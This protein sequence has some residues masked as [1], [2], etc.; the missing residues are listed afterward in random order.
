MDVTQVGEYIFAPDNL[1]DADV[2]IVLG[3]SDWRRPGTRAVELYQEGRVG[4]LL[5]TG[6]YNSKI[7]A[8]EAREMAALALAS[9]VPE[10]NILV[11]PQGRPYRSEHDVFQ[12]APRRQNRPWPVAV[13]FAGHHPLSHQAGDH[14]A[15]R[16]FPSPIEIGWVCYPSRHYSSSNWR[17]SRQG[18][19]HVRSEVSKIEK[20]YAVP[21]RESEVWT[22]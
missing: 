19:E 9:G 7:K 3:M 10:A 21:V 4:R 1:L 12:G 6:G 13:D 16:H 11:E 2:A 20:Y 22:A 18:R 14:R 17:Y 8:T 5:F 15:R